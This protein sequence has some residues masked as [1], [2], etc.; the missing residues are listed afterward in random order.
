MALALRADEVDCSVANT[1]V[2]LEARALV[3]AFEVDSEAA[4]SFA[5][6][7]LYA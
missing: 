5:Y 7:L 1:D 4:L 2:A 6:S 3:S